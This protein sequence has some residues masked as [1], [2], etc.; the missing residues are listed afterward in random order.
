LHS[1]KPSPFVHYK[2]IILHPTPPTTPTPT[3]HLRCNTITQPQGISLS[4]IS[5]FQPTYI[6]DKRGASQHTH[7]FHCHRQTPQTN[8][9]LW[10]RQNQLFNLKKILYEHNLL[11]IKNSHTKERKKRQDIK[12]NYS[13]T[14]KLNNHVTN[15]LYTLAL[16][17]RTLPFKP[18]SVTWKKHTS[19]KLCP[20]KLQP[21][22]AAI[23]LTNLISSWRVTK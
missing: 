2:P 13:T 11:L 17:S 22:S 3:P 14:Q 12:T 20:K 16:T 15:E 23:S 7:K 18:E 1:Y 8:Y 19:R 9:S 21:K 10:I 4:Y 5:S 6:K